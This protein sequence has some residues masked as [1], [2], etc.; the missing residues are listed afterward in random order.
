MFHHYHTDDKGI[1]TAANLIVATQN[2]AARIAMGV[3][4]SAKSLITGGNVPEGLLN[5]VEMAFLAYDP[6]LGCAT[7]ALPG[8]MPL[9]IEVRDPHGVPL[10][11]LRR[12][13]DGS[14]HRE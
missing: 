4:K 6:C 7:H 8:S 5:M 9:W 2:N 12:D 1:I 13:S 11:T 3:E 10:A 14:I